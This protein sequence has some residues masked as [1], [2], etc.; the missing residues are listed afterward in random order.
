MFVFFLFVLFHV[1]FNSKIYWSTYFE[2]CH[3]SF[4]IY[5]DH[6]NR[7]TI[8]SILNDLSS[9]GKWLQCH[10]ILCVNYYGIYTKRFIK[11]IEFSQQDSDQRN[12]RHRFN[13]ISAAASVSE[14]ILIKI[15]SKQIFKW[16]ILLNLFLCIR[17]N[18]IASLKEIQ[19]AISSMP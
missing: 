9:S 12:N 16:F 1:V 8:D 14:L 17:W 19:E 3:F 4:E 2:L 15:Q 18:I 5:R 7:L 6:G 10:W 13:S 11:T